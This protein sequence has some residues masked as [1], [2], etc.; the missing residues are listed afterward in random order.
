MKPVSFSIDHRILNRGFYLSKVQRFGDI[1]VVTYD[2]RLCKPYTD[3]TMTISMAHSLEHVLATLVREWCE[4]HK[5]WDIH[6]I[7]IGPMGCMTGFYI[8]LAFQNH[9]SYDFMR[10][11]MEMIVKYCYSKRYVETIPANS[12]K[13]CGNYHTLDSTSLLFAWTLFF[14]AW[15]ASGGVADYPD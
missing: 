3:P 7:Y 1:D 15:E 12:P 10:E 11:T 9:V 14:R 13:E 6:T 2:L 5:G 8:V 4:E